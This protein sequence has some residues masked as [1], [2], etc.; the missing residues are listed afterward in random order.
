MNADCFLIKVRFIVATSSSHVYRKQ[1]VRH[2]ARAPQ[3]QLC[4]VSA[5]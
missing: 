2:V 1:R 3:E 5:V 4:S